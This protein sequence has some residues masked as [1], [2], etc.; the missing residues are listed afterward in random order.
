METLEDWA[1][2]NI[3]G[4]QMV[5][6]KGAE[7]QFQDFLNFAEKLGAKTRV[8]STHRSKSIALPVVE[9]TTPYGVRCIARDNFHDIKV[10]VWA[11]SPCDHDLFGLVAG[12][13]SYLAGCYFEGFV[14][15]W[16]HKPFV[17]GSDKF[18][19]C[20]GY[21]EL[22]PFALALR[23]KYEPVPE[24]R[25]KPRMPD[26]E[27]F[28]IHTMMRM[29]AKNAY[30][31]VIYH[32]PHISGFYN[33]FDPGEEMAPNADL[34]RKALT[35]QGEAYDKVSPLP[36]PYIHIDFSGGCPR[37]YDAWLSTLNTIIK[38]R[39]EDPKVERLGKEMGAVVN[40]YRL[41]PEL[42]ELAK[43]MEL[44]EVLREPDHR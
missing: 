20:L 41:T 39:R 42:L 1:K 16:V 4:D 9:F 3:P 40:V 32:R 25:R 22:E 28:R 44:T 30:F 23:W 26:H 37:P 24:D 35:Q 31:P 43:R 29:V 38:E 10:S 21:R 2:A 14:S 11:P 8:V 34:L 36:V 18:S 5:Y 13:D 6:K 33:F 15:E 17:L 27:Y 7:G 19:V 12:G